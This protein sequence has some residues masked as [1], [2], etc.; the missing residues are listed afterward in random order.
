ME[1]FENINKPNN[2]KVSNFLFSQVI[3]NI[4]LIVAILIAFILILSRNT[5]DS[6]KHKVDGLNIVF[7]N[8]D[9]I[10]KNYKLFQDLKI[11]LEAETLRLQKDLEKRQKALESKFIA[12]QNKIKTGNISID[13]ARKTEENLSQQQQELIK[14]NEMY[15]QQIAQRE[16]E[17]TERILDSVI[18]AI[19][20]YN[21]SNQ[22]DF[23][24]G[25]SKGAGILYANPK[26]DITNEILIILNNRYKK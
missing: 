21:Q 7:V 6:S 25:Y 22:F 10:M 24:L 4:V 8:S 16:L 2:R 3:I 1:N 13:E 19:R 14:L 23:I 5:S 20:L 17:M 15:T 11:E 18:S 9:T 12:Y 26:L